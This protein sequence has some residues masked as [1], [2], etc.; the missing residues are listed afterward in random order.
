LEE[1][2]SLNSDYNTMMADNSG[3]LFVADGTK[4][5]AFDGKEKRTFDLG[6][7]NKINSF[8]ESYND[9]IVLVYTDNRLNAVEKKTGHIQ[10]T[11]DNV[12]WFNGALLGNDGTVFARRGLGGPYS[13]F[14]GT[15]GHYLWS[16]EPVNHAYMTVTDSGKVLMSESEHPNEKNKA[17][18]YE[19]DPKSGAPTRK[20]SIDTKRYGTIDKVCMADANGD[21]MFVITSR[22]VTLLRSRNPEKKITDEPEEAIPETKPTIE[23]VDDYVIIDGIKIQVKP[24]QGR[25]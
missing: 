25:G 20:L 11:I 7:G 13:G 9:K 14:D 2:I 12:P 10:Y 6:A 3:N 4:I 5:H 18:I 23:Q 17:Y 1:D 15:D 19:V 22:G 21:E 24:E 16:F 8:S